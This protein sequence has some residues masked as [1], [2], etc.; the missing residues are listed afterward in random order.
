MEPHRPLLHRQ[1]RSRCL[2]A[3]G[4]YSRLWSGLVSLSQRRLGA[5]SRRT[6]GLRTLLGMDMGF[7]RALGM[8]PLPL[9]TMVPIRRSMGVV[10]GS[11]WSWLRLRVSLPAHLGACLCFLLRIRRRGWIRSWLWL[12]GMA[13]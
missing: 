3:L 5:V 7:L 10:A 4:K 8:G 6:L 1:R 9:R 12:G 11:G 2:R 13:S